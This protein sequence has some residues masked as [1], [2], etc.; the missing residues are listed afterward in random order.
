M[1]G[2]KTEKGALAR[3]QRDGYIVK[4]RERGGEGEDSVD[5]LIGP[6]GKVEIG[7]RGVAGLVRE[8]YGDGGGDEVERRLVRS[9]GDV[10][11]AKKVVGSGAG[12]G[13]IDGE[14]EG[15]GEAEVEAGR[16]EDGERSAGIVNGNRGVEPEGRQ[17]RRSLGGNRRP[18]ADEEDD[19][20]EEEDDDEGEEEDE[21][22]NE[23]EDEEDEDEEDDDEE[24][25]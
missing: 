20:G 23:D 11:I 4:V 10:V 17:T 18:R 3:M 1:L 2:E 22:G 16:E 24:E 21:E 8:V 12:E 15:D 19:E 14:E 6:R 25:D 9:L 13:G 7:E 5:F